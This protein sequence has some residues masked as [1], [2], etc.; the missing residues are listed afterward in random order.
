MTSVIQ[1]VPLAELAAPKGLI[2]G[3]FGSSLGKKD[4]VASGVPVIRGQ[5]LESSSRFT[6]DKFVYV[7]PEKVARDLAGNVARPGDVI[8]TQRGTLGQVG[9]VPNEPNQQYVISQSQ[10][11]FRADPGKADARY[12]Y[13]C[14]RAP[15]MIRLIERRAIVTGVPHIN[16]GALVDLPVPYRP[17]REQRAIADVLSA[18][19]DKIAVNRRIRDAC[20]SLMATRFCHEA[21]PALENVAGDE[22]LP[23]GWHRTTL[24]AVLDVLETGDRPRG[25]VSGYSNG[26]PSLGAESVLGLALYKDAKTKFVPVEFFERMSRGIARDRDVLLYKDGGRPGEFE[27]H[28]A[29]LGG[30]FPFKAYCINEHVYR[31]RATPP[32]T[33][34][35]LYC[36]LT[37][38]LLLQAMRR[39]G[40]G[41]A[42]PGLNS[43][44]VKALPVVVPPKGVLASFAAVAESLVSAA[45]AAGRESQVLAAT[46]DVLLPRLLSGELRVRDAQ[47]LV[48][49]AV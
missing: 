26:V 19:D 7:T 14:F 35:Y 12:V 20:A 31:L 18:F 21:R 28:V 1:T 40:T 17:L 37:H 2:G 43:T 42:I 36:W 23:S 30:G 10:M 34:E 45:L 41:V 46:R 32:L 13:Y 49:E 39:S 38:R 33:Q 24:G 25:G 3:P 16:L 44:A 48:D 8:F 15:E 11:R 29:L 5:N 9:L 47:K 4:Y 22:P 6:S 27:P